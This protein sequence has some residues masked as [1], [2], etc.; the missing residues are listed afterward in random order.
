LGLSRQRQERFEPEFLWNYELGWRHDANDRS[1]YTDLTAFYMQR[2]DMQVR[3]GAQLEVGNPNSFGFVTQN[4]SRGHN[5]G[6]E[7]SSQWA[8]VRSLE[9]G[10]TVGWLKTRQSGALNEDGVFVASR[11]QAHAPNYQVQVNVTYRHAAGL[12]ARVDY[13]AV[14][15]FFFDVP[16]DH[17]QRSSAYDLVNL[18]FGFEAD[19][20]S[21]HAWA[22]NVFDESYAT[23]GFYFG[24]E[25]PDYPNKLYIQ[26]GDPRTF[27]V[28]AEW[29]FP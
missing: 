7:A 20:W 16:T 6:L 23:R 12:M 15:A 10:A 28:S 27:G 24:N 5:Y 1:W 26:N 3:S 4:V 18:K 19:R 13:S 8:I 11:E 29:S 17:D 9:L 22:R 2:R 21:V 14:D 25:P